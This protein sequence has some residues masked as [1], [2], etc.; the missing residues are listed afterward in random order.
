MDLRYYLRVLARRKWLIFLVVLTAAFATF[1]FSLLLPKR[2]KAEAKFFTNIAQRYSFQTNEGVNP[3]FEMEAQ[4]NNIEVQITSSQVLSLLAYRLILHDLSSQEEAFR[5]TEILNST[6]TVSDIRDAQQFYQT[7]LD[8]LQPLIT[9]DGIKESYQNILKLMRYDIKSL[10]EDLS[11]SRTPGSDI[12]NISYTSQNPQ[13]SFFAVNALCNEFNRYYEFRTIE[14]WKNRISFYSAEVDKSRRQLENTI[15]AQQDFVEI[16]E[17]QPS[18]IQARELLIQLRHLELLRSEEERRIRSLEQALRSMSERITNSAPQNNIQSTYIDA[19]SLFREQI[20]MYHSKLIDQI[21]EGQTYEGTE[22]TL[23]NY[24]VRMDN[25]LYQFLRSSIANLR[26]LDERLYVL[27]HDRQLAQQNARSRIEQIDRHLESIRGKIFTGKNSQ[28][29]VTTQNDSVQQAKQA[30]FKVLE[31]LY[32]ARYFGLNDDSQLGN[33]DYA[34]VPDEPVPSR[35]WLHVLIAALLSLTLCVLMLV[36]LEMLDAT[37]KTG[38]HFERI[39]NL[40]LLSALNYLN[41]DRLDLIALFSDTNQQPDLE[42]YK[43][44][45][46]KIRFEVI[47]SG[48]KVFMLTSTRPG[49]G[50]TSLLF[51]LGYSLSL[52]HKKIL[53]VD[54]HFKNNQLTRMT[55]ALPTLERYMADE[56]Q[57]EELVS[58]SGLEGVFVLGCE[59]GNYTPS[60]IF[61]PP[62]RFNSLLERLGETYDYIFLEGPALNLYSGS[63]ELIQYVDK[64]IP[65][66]SAK[67]TIKQTDKLSIK[68]LK[69]LNGKLMGTVL[70]KVELEDIED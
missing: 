21:A 30:Y 26:P 24:Q 68:F 17:D 36:G 19:I 67:A 58:P 1:L 20:A 27:Q 16:M 14:T 9:S 53:L 32:E 13:L 35:R 31:P 40:T 63:K 56:I 43:Q 45:M 46:R 52:N 34:Q 3:Q 51:S 60:E 11:I 61:V 7:R 38:A 37:I 25:Q 57:F 48:G 18:A 41:G 4:L 50:K 23:A 55:S 5:S 44:L 22:D 42:A 39:S 64:V 28:A 6:F 54:T 2:Y 29:T 10:L 12:L 70:N 65:I 66:F 8:S 59:G 49:A 62:D 33:F 69:G 47:S 15:A